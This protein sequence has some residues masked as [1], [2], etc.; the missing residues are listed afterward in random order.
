MCRSGEI[1]FVLWLCSF[2]ALKIWMEKRLWNILS[3]RWDVID[4]TITNSREYGA[5]QR[6]VLPFGTFL[7]RIVRG[8]FRVIT[9][10]SCGTI[11]GSFEKSSAMHCS[12]GKYTR[13]TD[14]CLNPIAG[15]WMC[16]GFITPAQ[17][18]QDRTAFYGATWSPDWAFTC[19]IW[20]DMELE[21]T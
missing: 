17:K 19:I 3:S 15:D 10:H 5:L 9:C 21:L 18:Q 12:G 2:N 11:G 20:R 7:T 4:F 6:L 8:D 13:I 14:I 1:P 16:R